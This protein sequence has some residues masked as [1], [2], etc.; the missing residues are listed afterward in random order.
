MTIETQIGQ[1]AERREE[2]TPQ[3]LAMINQIE[4]AVRGATACT[5]GNLNIQFSNGTVVLSGNTT[6]NFMK[7][8]AGTAALGVINNRYDFSNEI[9]V[10]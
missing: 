9:H 2:L 6:T 1:S 3:G 7:S 5:I 10:R 8:N 4:R